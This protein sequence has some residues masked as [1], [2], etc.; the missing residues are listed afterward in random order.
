MKFFGENISCVRGERLVFRGLNFAVEPGGALVLTG[1]NGSGKT[2]LLRVMAGL[3][4]ATVGKIAWS[5]GPIS[6]DP[7]KHHGRLHFI[8][9]L[10]A[11]K[12]VLS[13]GENLEMWARLHGGTDE[14]I[15]MAI[16]KLKLDGFEDL[17]GRYLSA[18]QRRRL[19]LARLVASEAPLWILDEPTIALDEGSVAAVRALISEHRDAG[20]M[21]VI[22]TNV[23]LGLSDTTKLDMR[24]YAAGQDDIWEGV[25]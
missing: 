20:G 15:A 8:G 24:D 3:N 2:S 19:S 4:R 12:P 11:Q 5:D 18:G 9:H 23:E 6:D 13:V 14:K 17:P 10:D 16:K 22:A 7:E 1:N 25:S 21:A